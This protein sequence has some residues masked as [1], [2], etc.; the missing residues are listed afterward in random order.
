[1]K[2]AAR[3]FVAEL[4]AT[5]IAPLEAATDRILREVGVRFEEDE[6]TLELWRAH[7]FRIDGDRVYLDG[8]ELRALIRAHAPSAFTLLARDPA[9]DRTVGAAH[10]PVFAPVYGPP[11]VILA[12]GERVMGSRQLY[13]DLVAMADRHPGIANTGH[14][15]CVMNDVLESERPLEMARAHLEGSA[16]S[17]MGTIASPEAA[18]AV[19]ALTRAT[20]KRAPLADPSCHLLH[21]INST[22][23]L[24]FKPNPLRCLRQIARAG[25]GCM[26]TSYIMAGATGPVTVA[27]LLAQGYAECLAGLALAQLWRP[28]TPVVMGLFAAQFSM[29]SMQPWFGD[30]LSHTVQMHAV[31]LA[32]HLGIPVRGDG[33]VTSS[34]LDDAQAGFEGGRAT[35]IAL[36]AGCDFVLHAAGWLESGRTTSMAKYDRESA[37]LEPWVSAL[38]RAAI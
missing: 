38:D 18:E 5:A 1:M 6:E 3:A 7:G 34:C 29:R 28:G 10:P 16:K 32:R 25:E 13:R 26:V 4:S 31:A 8:A 35:A 12:N 11:N 24:T 20:L 33:G 23:P 36:H 21:L 2:A 37:A 30:P 22:P 19:I 15:V 9:W 27:G 17:F 14:M